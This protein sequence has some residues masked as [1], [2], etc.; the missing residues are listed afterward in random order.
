M[1]QL[2]RQMAPLVELLSAEYCQRTHVLDGAHNV[3]N[4]LEEG[5]T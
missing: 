1:R 5:S 4:I 2:V 3:L